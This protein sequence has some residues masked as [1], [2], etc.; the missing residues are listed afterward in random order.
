M[1]SD[2]Q[3]RLDMPESAS[4]DEIGA[5]SRGFERLLARLNEHTSTCVPWAASSRMSCARR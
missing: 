3:L 1:G 5:L 4:A 2:G